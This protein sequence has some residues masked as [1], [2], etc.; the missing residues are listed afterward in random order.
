MKDTIGPASGGSE[1]RIG[2]GAALVRAYA[3]STRMEV[4][5]S[6]EGEPSLSSSPL[7]SKF[8]KV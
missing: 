2:G 6:E 5:F 7:N 8:Q 4:L 3:A 1:L